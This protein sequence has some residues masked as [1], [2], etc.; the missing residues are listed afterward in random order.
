MKILK[1]SAGSGKTYRLA[2]TYIEMLLA[3]KDRFAYRH[4]LAVTFTNKATTEMKSRIV[5]ELDLLANNTSQSPY[6]SDFVG[7]YG[8]KEEIS[9]RASTLLS[10]ILND[11]GSFSISTID[12]FFQKV[13]RSFAREVGRFASYQIELDKDSLVHQ[14]VD[15]VLKSIGQENG[16][17]E[18]LVNCAMDQ[19]RRTGRFNIEKVIFDAASKI[20]SDAFALASGED[21]AALYTKEAIDAI[22]VKCEDIRKSFTEK[23]VEA[24]VKVVNAFNDAG[25]PLAD[26]SRGAFCKFQDIYMTMTPKDNIPVPSASFKAMCLDPET[27]FAKKNALRYQ[28]CVSDYLESVVTDFIALFETEG[29]VYNTAVAMS[30][31][32][33]GLGMAMDVMQK[34]DELIREKD[35]LTIDDSNALLKT[36]IGE[37]DVPLVYEKIGTRFRHFLLDEF[38]DTSSVQW[39]NFLPLIEESEANSNDNLIVGDVKQSIYRWRNSDWRL[40]ASQVM[41]DIPGSDDSESLA[42]NWRSAPEVVDFN[43]RFFAFA[44]AEIDKAYNSGHDV[45]DISS[46]ATQ[47]ARNTQITDGSVKI[48]MMPPEE[49]LQAVCKAVEEKLSGGVQ[50]GKIAVLVRSNSDGTV[51]ANALMSKGIPVISDDSLKVKS[52]LSVRRLAAMLSLSINPDDVLSDYIVKSL[53]IELPEN[54]LSV[55]A[56]VLNCVDTLKGVTPEDVEADSLH[57]QSFLDDIHESNAKGESLR[58]FLS[59]WQSSDPKVTCP[60]NGQSVRIMTVHKAKGLEFEHVIFPY[61]ES[62]TL[63]RSESRWLKPDVEGTALDGI[64]P[65]YFPVALSETSKETLFAKDYQQEKLMQA[66][67]NLNVFYVAFTRAVKD[68]TV[69]SAVPTKTFRTAADAGKDVKYTNLSQMLYTF[70]DSVE[71]PM[72]D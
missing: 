36:I 70:R 54:D 15:D 53:G 64:P 21:T 60:D 44:A 25:I 47:V 59:G 41:K 24:A 35:V 10:H 30:M 4:I 31:E 26:T 48:L 56:F 46:T 49:E 9:A 3:S 51:I 29:P 67:D 19:I 39:H 52:A 57:L 72:N 27:W 66:V 71:L 23:V 37:C 32:L 14:S 55:E 33:F 50:P 28:G 13:L 43:N 17:K 8:T 69:I 5:R 2:K 62:V 22:R 65:M 40:L 11:Y 18:W 63:W 16:N 61:A 34:Y 42:D 20:K 58:E 6:I 45:Q 7:K 38:Q 12:A 68:L 1:A